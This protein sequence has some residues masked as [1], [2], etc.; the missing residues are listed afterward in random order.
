MREYLN[1]R[2][3]AR[4]GIVV[5][6]MD[7]VHNAVWSAYAHQPITP[8]CLALGGFAFF[9]ASLRRLKKAAGEVA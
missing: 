6:G 3:L 9:M 2:N 1:L 8:T 4:V 7:A 5:S